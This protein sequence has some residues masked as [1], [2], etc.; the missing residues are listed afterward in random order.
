MTAPTPAARRG[1]LVQPKVALP[2]IA[3]AV[4]IVALL[5]PE[6]SGRSGDARLSSRLTASQGASALYEL[7]ARLGWNASQRLVDSIPS[8]D[9][10]AVHLVLDPALPLSALETRELLDR[11]RRGAGLVYVLGG[12]PMADSLRVRSFIGS[13]GTLVPEDTSGCGDRGERIL[14]DGLPFWPDGETHI[15]AVQWRGTPPRDIT[16]LASVRTGATMGAGR[17]RTVTETPAAVGFSLGRGRVAVLADPDLLR[18]D[19]VRVCRWGASVAAVRILEYVSADG[20]GGG[21]RQRL[22]FDE[23]H[24]G[25]GDQPGTLTGIFRF[26]G[27]TASGHFMLQLAGAGL[28]LLLAV[29]PRLLAPRPAERIER[30]SPLEHV[31]AL[32]RAYRM[33][34]ASRTATSRLLHGVRRRVEL[35]LGLRAAAAGDEAFLTWAQER[36]PSRAAEVELVRRALAQPLPRR[37]LA[38]VGAALSRL[39]VALT[40]FPRTS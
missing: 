32:A 22:V 33:V 3:A 20:P 9:T 13:A 31:D 8:G 37:D 26:L 18:N 30:R 35:A 6:Q 34:G 5:T 1:R 17:A 4:I 21:R 15:L 29:G 10:T 36:V 28:L 11:V 19:V 14:D 27:R 24:Q 12:G 40:S 23:Y 16:Q 39:E 2:I 25:F 38:A 7:A